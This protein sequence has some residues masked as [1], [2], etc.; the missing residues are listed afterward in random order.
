MKIK[1]VYF[2]LLFTA[3][4][5]ISCQTLSFLNLDKEAINPSDVIIT[6]T[7][8]VSGF[9]KIEMNTYGKVILSQGE[10]ESLNIRGSD[11]VVPVIQTSVRAGNLVIQTKENI[12]VTNLK[13]DS[14]LTFTIVVKDL[15]SITL[16]G[17]ADIEMNILATS[18]LE[19][20]MSGAGAIVLGQLDAVSLDIDLSGFG[21]VNISGEVSNF[22]VD[23]SGAGN[24]KTADLKAQTADITISG[25]GN[26]TLW[27]TDQLSGNISG[28][29]NVSYYGNPQADVESTG[30][31][32]FKSLG[33]K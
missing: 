26:A 9:T 25:M 4:L 20:T 22:Q 21:D 2:F 23:I 30:L 19:V 7:R 28:G 6:E 11:N 29:G 15:T 32:Q 1:F 16:S 24:I 27:V 18:E 10:K 3:L 5:I 17:A 33:N 8:E 12:N 13:E 14:I 31:G